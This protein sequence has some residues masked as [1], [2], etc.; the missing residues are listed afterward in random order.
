MLRAL[1]RSVATAVLLATPA[2]GHDGCGLP[3]PRFAPPFARVRIG[4][5]IGAFEFGVVRPIHRHLFRVETERYWVEPLFETRVV[6]YDLCGRPICGR[7]LVRDGYWATR[8]FEVCAC[9][10]TLRR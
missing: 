9:G 4:M 8:T 6:G 5:P 7:V 2:F 3:L 1:L 10:A